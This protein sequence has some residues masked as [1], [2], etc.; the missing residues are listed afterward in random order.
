MPAPLKPLKRVLFALGIF[1]GF[2]LHARDEW[3]GGMAFRSRAPLLVWCVF[4]T[5]AL[6]L[7]PLVS[8]WSIIA[9]HGVN[10]ESIFALNGS[11]K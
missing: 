10:F 2:P 11:G 5:S 4:M 6:Y 8:A 3:K 1:G 9:S 7:I